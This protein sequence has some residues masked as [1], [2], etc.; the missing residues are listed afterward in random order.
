MPVVCLQSSMTQEVER[1]EQQRGWHQLH[2]ARI[3][4]QSGSFSPHMLTYLSGI[5]CLEIAMMRLVKVDQSRHH[6]TH[7]KPGC[8]SSFASFPQLLP[9]LPCGHL[10][11]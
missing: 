2:K 8:G 5:V 7:A 1:Q 6:F 11:T 4:D 3:A 9:I 10:L